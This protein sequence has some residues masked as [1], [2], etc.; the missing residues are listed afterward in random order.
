CRHTYNQF[1]VKLPDLVSR[2]HL[3]SALQA[4]GIATAV[5]YPKPLHL[6]PCFVERGGLPAGTLPVCEQ[7]ALTTLALPIFPGMTADEQQQVVV[8]LKAGCCKPD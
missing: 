8:A 4:E 2:D 7:A 6:Q 1:V 3:Q 5:Y